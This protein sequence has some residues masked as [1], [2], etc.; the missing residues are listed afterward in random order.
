MLCHDVDLDL[1]RNLY[2]IVLCKFS[3]I[4]HHGPVLSVKKRTDV[5]LTFFLLNKKDNDL[6][7]NFVGS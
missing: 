7:F 4:N 5:V 3:Y 6:L 1:L 2:A